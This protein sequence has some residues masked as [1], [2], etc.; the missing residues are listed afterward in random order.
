MPPLIF[1]HH[2][3]CLRCPPPILKK[4]KKEKLLFFKNIF[5]L[6]ELLKSKAQ[7]RWINLNKQ[8]Q[9]TAVYLLYSRLE[10]DERIEHGRQLLFFHSSRYDHIVKGSYGLIR[11]LLGE[12][13]MLLS[14]CGFFVFLSSWP[15]RCH[16]AKATAKKKKRRGGDSIVVS[17]IQISC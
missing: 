1:P 14:C 5:E 4:R 17:C 9:L 7:L 6:N 10:G 2:R 3:S 8:V 15:L 16:Q 11:F 12:K 13:Y